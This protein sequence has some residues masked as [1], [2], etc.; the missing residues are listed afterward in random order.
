MVN[1]M[2]MDLIATLGEQKYVQLLNHLLKKIG[3]MNKQVN[4]VSTLNIGAR[5]Q[6]SF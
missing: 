1:H 2:P 4:L 5:I 6:M 3:S